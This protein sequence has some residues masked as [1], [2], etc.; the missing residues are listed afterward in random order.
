HEA[1]ADQGDRAARLSRCRRR[2]VSELGL[3]RRPVAAGRHAGAQPIDDGVSPG[4]GDSVSSG[5]R[6]RDAG[7]RG[8]GRSRAARAPRR[9]RAPPARARAALRRET[10]RAFRLDAAAVCR[11]R[12]VLALSGTGRRS[13]TRNRALPTRWCAGRRSD[14]IQRPAHAGVPHGRWPGVVSELEAVQRAHDQPSGSSD[15]HRHGTAARD[16]RRIGGRRMKIPITRP[17]FG[18]E[19]RRALVAPL[20]TGWVVQGPEVDRFEKAFAAYAGARHAM[21]TTSCTTALHLAVAALGL[22]PGDEVIV[23]GFTWVATPNVVEHMGA[24]P[25]FCDI[26]LATFN[27]DVSRI[28]R[29]ITK[30][31]VGIMPVHLFGLA[32]DM[33]QVLAIARKHSLWVVEDAACGFAASYRGRHVGT[34]GDAG[35]FSFHPRKSITTG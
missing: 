26:D 12:D 34:F 14:R 6:R 18:E 30:N 33:D 5:L 25:V 22:K 3:R 1:G 23:P 11:R 2:G 17:F 4:R 27:I 31:T 28:E 29:L 32:A 10:A 20:D 13:R 19:E 7:R 8:R 21:A 16:R 15:A 9:V 24:T 35:C